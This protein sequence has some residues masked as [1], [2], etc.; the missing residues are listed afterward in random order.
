MK[1]A[2]LTVVGSDQVGIIA[3]FTT[4]LMEHNVNIVDLAQ[5]VLDD[6]FT[7]TVVVDIEKIS[8]S[9]EALNIALDELSSELNLKVHFMLSDIFTAMHRI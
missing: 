5:N 1:K 9:F 4:L 3:K 8:A 2:I 6:I 7:M